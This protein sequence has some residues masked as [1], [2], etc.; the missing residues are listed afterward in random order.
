MKR[1]FLL[2]LSIFF[3]MFI[4]SCSED[5]VINPIPS[6]TSISP[7]GK[8]SRMPSFT[9]TVDGTN[10]MNGST[11]VFNGSNKTTTYVS[12]T[13]VTCQIETQDITAAASAN[14]NDIGLSKLGDSQ[15]TVLV[16]NP[17]P[18]GGNSNSMNFTIAS[19]PS[20]IAYKT[21]S[22][23]TLDSHG[24]VT[25]VDSSN[26]IN[27]FWAEENQPHKS[28]IYFIRSTDRGATWSQ[29]VNI[30][31]TP[32]SSAGPSAKIGSQG[33]LYVTWVDWLTDPSKFDVFFAYSTNNGTTWSTPVNITNDNVWSSS[34]TIIC[35]QSTNV[36]IAWRSEYAKTGLYY[37]KS[38]DSGATWSLPSKITDAIEDEISTPALGIDN[39]GNNLYLVWEDRNSSDDADIYFTK[40]TDKA[41][42]WSTPVNLTNTIGDTEDPDISIDSQGYVNLVYIDH[43]PGA[44]DDLGWDVYHIRSVDGGQTFSA[45]SNVSGTA[46]DVYSP[47]IAVD[48]AGNINIAW[49]Q[50]IQDL[51]HIYYS[52]SINN[53]A[54]WG[55]QINVSALCPKVDD[56]AMFVD[57]YGNIYLTWE[58][59]SNSGDDEVAFT[60]SVF[61]GLN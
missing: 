38:S 2:F 30:S 12:S 27:V 44:V 8:V 34:P 55:Q 16:S 54:S 58:Y 47:N 50:V 22:S 59:K 42:T 23:P 57:Y 24:I 17:T 14:S 61:P 9:L 32:T 31:N 52:R 39:A 40:S 35:D 3:L 20:F 26:N 7:P 10:F 48:R 53:G 43:D 46:L 11:I 13:Q 56:P 19:Y 41:V 15:V 49:K 25:V 1:N 33:Q 60:R 5:E 18:G 6:I 36:Y 21:L 4:V 28:D 51:S 37:A 45:P 29:P